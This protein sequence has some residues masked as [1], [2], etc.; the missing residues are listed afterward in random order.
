MRYCAVYELTNRKRCGIA[1]R[2]PFDIR[3]PKGHM[4]SKTLYVLDLYHPPY[5]LL[6]RMQYYSINFQLWRN[7]TVNC[8]ILEDPTHDFYRK[9]HHSVS[10]IIKSYTSVE[11]VRSIL[12]LLPGW[13]QL[14]IS[15]HAKW[16]TSC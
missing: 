15:V 8:P 14:I 9:V 5:A 12:P 16:M 13:P 1:L 3:V 4:R 10:R 7:L 2:L 6:R 11:S